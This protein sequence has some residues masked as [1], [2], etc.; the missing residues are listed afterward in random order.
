MIKAIIFDLWNTLVYSEPPNSL[1]RFAE[2]IGKSMSDYSYLKVLERN[3]MLER[4]DD[5][6]KVVK[7]IL[8]ELKI[9]PDEGLV[10]ELGS[11]LSEK[12]IEK[13]KTYPGTIEALLKLKG[14]FRLGIISNDYDPGAFEV[15]DRKYNLR[16]TFDHIVLSYE[17]GMIKPDPGMFRIVLE[18]FGVV[19]EEALMVGD[20]LK[21]D[22]EAAGKL[23]IKG[24]LFDIKNRHPEHPRR[25]RSLEE[26]QEYLR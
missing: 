26:L 6:E 9:K 23:G 8:R 25:I 19:P 2:K 24:V 12:D 16:K 11:I 5:I 15:I 1:D 18:R 21:D 3:L 14:R 17:V 13:I 22:I 20:S 10:K 4:Y 7:N